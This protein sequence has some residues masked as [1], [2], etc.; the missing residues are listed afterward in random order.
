MPFKQI[1]I[2]MFNDI[3]IFIWNGTEH[4]EQYKH[5]KYTELH[6]HDNDMNLLSKTLIFSRFHLSYIDMC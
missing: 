2:V 1:V 5:A 3:I 4:N 6:F